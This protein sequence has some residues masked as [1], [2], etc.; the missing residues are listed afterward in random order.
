M[1][2]Q[3]RVILQV[4]ERATGHLDAATILGIARRE[5]AEIDRVTVY[6]TLALLKRHGLVDE[7]DLLHL[8][9]V[10][11]YYE[12]RPIQEHFHLAC[13]RCGRVVEFASPLFDKI[14]GQIEREVNFRVGFA[15]LEI[16][17]Y[18]QSCRPRP[19]S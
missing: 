16:G 3:R 10:G 12:Q 8:G 7:L 15:R 13:L 1:T 2:R 9:G 18:C 19:A 4:I 17:G 14:K 6:R 11:H 5:H